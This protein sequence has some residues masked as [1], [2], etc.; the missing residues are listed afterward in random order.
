[1]KSS[2]SPLALAGACVLARTFGERPALAHAIINNLG[3]IETLFSLSEKERE[4]VFGPYSR[5][6][7]S[8]TDKA[9]DRGFKDLEDISR[10]GAKAISVEDPLYPPLLRECKDAPIILFYKSRSN[11]GDLFSQ[12][13]ISIVGTRDISPYGAEWTG[14]ITASFAQSACPPCIVSGLAFGVDITAHSSALRYNMSTIAVI[15]T[16]ID[17]IYPHSHF[18]TAERIADTPGCA[19]VSD[20]FPGT[21]TIKAYFIRRNRII[22]GLSMSTIL[23]ESRKKGGGLITSHMAWGYGR[24]VYALPGRIDDVRSEGCN[25]LI[26][27]KVAE[28]IV[29]LPQ[30]SRKLR[31]GTKVQNTSW[32][33]SV[34]RFYKGREMQEDLLNMACTIE[35]CNGIDIEGLC[36]KCGYDYSRTLNLCGIL[37][38]DGFIQ[39]D[40]LQRCIILA[41]NA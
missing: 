9:L 16:G 7:D 2:P 22:A 3:S 11:P 23:I 26:E 25:A 40:L 13:M 10:L 36:D 37:Q 41:K 39:T 28:P 35:R 12:K 17:E 32:S 8:L 5:Y 33:E 19:V 38:K 1:M 24:E 30:L 34:G 20:F 4:S 14:R 6:R 29:S 21:P 31:L 18:G 27:E 15:P